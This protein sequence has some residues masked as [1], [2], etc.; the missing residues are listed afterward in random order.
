MDQI[1]LLNQRKAL[2]DAGDTTGLKALESDVLPQVHEFLNGKISAEV[3]TAPLFFS[4]FKTFAQTEN[5]PVRTACEKALE[6]LRPDLDRFDEENGLLH[7]DDLNKSTIEHNLMVLSAYE[8]LN[9]FEIQK[10]D[11]LKFSVFSDLFRLVNQIDITDADSEKSKAAHVKFVETLI[12]SAKLQ[13]FME[14]SLDSN[15]ITESSYL[16]NVRQNMEKNLVMM[17][18]ADRIPAGESMNDEIKDQIQSEY[19]KLLD[20][21]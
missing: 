1:S 5:E 11:Q 15:K 4:F 3:E 9:P 12:E 14:L 10:N 13:T 16:N 2:T 19:Q 8:R 6:K 17:F 21:L 18:A 7:L 20:A